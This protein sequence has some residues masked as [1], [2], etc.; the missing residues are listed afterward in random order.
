MKLIRM[1]PF[2]LLPPQKLGLSAQPLNAFRAISESLDRT[3]QGH[4]L[5]L[6][7]L[8]SISQNVTYIGVIFFIPY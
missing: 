8:P 4:L 2:F 5:A 6:A 3:S 7:P 1:S